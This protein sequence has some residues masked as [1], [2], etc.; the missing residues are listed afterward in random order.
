M[1]INNFIEKIAKDS[2]T[3]I[4]DNSIYKIKLINKINKLLQNKDLQPIISKKLLDLRNWS[5]TYSE[6]LMIS[7]LKDFDFPINLE[8]NIPREQTLMGIN[9][10]ALPDIY[11]DSPYN[12]YF[13]VKRFSGVNKEL[14]DNIIREVKKSTCV[15]NIVANYQYDSFFNKASLAKKEI[16]ELEDAIEKG[17]SHHNSINYPNLSYTIHKEKKDMTYS[18]HSHNPYR[19][20]EQFKYYVFNHAD[21]I[22]KERSNILS[23][24]LSPKFNYEFTNLFD[25]HIGLR[26]LARR[27]FMELIND[28][29][30]IYE[31]NDKWGNCEIHLSNIAKRITAIV[32]YIDGLDETDKVYFFQNPNVHKDNQELVG[33]K[34][35]KMSI[36][37]KKTDID[38]YYDNFEFDNY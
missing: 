28:N 4:A 15:W 7:F 9:S 20:A 21:Q 5:G 10:H 26:S 13:E 36:D 30:K 14:T 33:I 25:A 16:K 23:F 34:Q 32:F 22:L 37:Y 38:F 1:L 8:K 27:V 35:L 29:R 18:V 2:K 19:F 11:L 24:V 3:V 6:I 12:L 17:L 31:L